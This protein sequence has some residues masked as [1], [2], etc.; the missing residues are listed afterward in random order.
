MSRFPTFKWCLLICLGITLVNTS[1]FGETSAPSTNLDLPQRDGVY[2][3]DL[4]TAL[5]L[6]NA[7]NLDVQIAREKVKEAKAL[8]ENARFQFLPTLSPG[9]SYRRHDNT[10]QAV[11]GQFLDIHKQSYA[12]GVMIGG[13]WDVG[14][15][16]YKSLAAKQQVKS[17]EYRLESQRQDSVIAVIQNYFDLQFAHAAIGVAAESI[18]ISTNYESQLGQAV[19]S[20]IAFKGD[21]LRI[22]VQ[23]E[24]GWLTLQQA[25]EQEKIAAAR[26]AQSLHLDP[27]IALVTHDSD[28]VPLILVE[29][30]DA[31]SPLVQEALATR[32]ELKEGRANYHAALE[33]KK[34][35][36][37]GPLIPSLGAQVFAGGL[38]GDSSAG[39]SR[40][41][42]QE[43]YF[44]GLSWKIGPGGIFD[45][46]RKKAAEA[47][48]Q[49]AQLNREKAKDEVTRQVVEALARIQSLT[50]QIESSRRALNAA[51]S[52]LALAQQ[53]REF[54]VGIVLENI[55]AEQD[56]TRARL[57]Y[58]K[59]VAEFNKAQYILKRAL[60]RI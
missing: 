50:G 38:G 47:G 33:N 10:I 58:L 20:G 23:A 46:T 51:E 34:G 55:Q 3:I 45:S 29:T 31:L 56:L 42:E 2:V 14:E 16:I 4:P 18:G 53:R 28:F 6:A 44:I 26:L 24:R 52:G 54:A 40:F 36:V 5:R 8:Q 9:L 57:D 11:D 41:G 27:S 32:S 7:Q 35:T 19:A 15:T 60:G 1:G 43:D 59:T 22:Q 48:L 30:N 49:M 39:T 21:Q 13:Q 25:K 37:Y 12:P 17:S